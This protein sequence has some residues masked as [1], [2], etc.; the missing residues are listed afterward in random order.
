MVAVH[1]WT[2]F[3]DGSVCTQGCGIGCVMSSPSGMVYELSVG[4]DFSCTNNQVEYEAL[5]TG[6]EY[7]ISMGVKHVEAFRDSR[8][9]VQQM[10]RDS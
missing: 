7:L 9:V 4:L 5:L 2:L 6:L 1:A 3:F 10:C 8:L